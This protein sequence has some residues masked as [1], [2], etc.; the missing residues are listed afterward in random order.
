MIG[1]PHILSVTDIER[2]I[3]AVATQLG[4]DVGTLIST[5]RLAPPYITLNPSEVY[6]PPLASVTSTQPL[7][8]GSSSVSFPGQ[9]QSI[10]TLYLAYSGASG[11]VAEAVGVRAY[12]GTTFEL[13]T[14]LQN[15]YGLSA[16]VQ[17]F[18]AF[19][20]GNVHVLLPGDT[21]YVP[22]TSATNN[23]NLSALA[24]LVDAFGTDLAWP[25]QWDAS[26]DLATVS[27]EAMAQQRFASV[28]GTDLQSLPLHPDFGAQLRAKLGSSSPD[29]PWPAYAREALMK[30]PEIMDIRNLQTTLAGSSLA[31]TGDSY[32]TGNNAP[33]S[34]NT[35]VSL[36]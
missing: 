34:V 10:N 31:I 3:E 11:L 15:S 32:V 20:V 36:A 13:S 28:L 17:M 16:Q 22:V 19:S 35:T 14:P 30:L 18:T 9:P 26:G 25:L 1:Q 4:T 24:E 21:V 2:G 12:D 23:F 8:A 6:G 27:G 7:T 5:N 33:L 29:T